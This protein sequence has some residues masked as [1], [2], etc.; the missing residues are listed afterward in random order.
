MSILR[1]LGGPCALP[2]AQQDVHGGT[3][4][5]QTLQM[6]EQCLLE[7]KLEG[8]RGSCAQRMAKNAHC[9]G[10]CALHCKQSHGMC[11]CMQ[12]LFNNRKC[13]TLANHHDAG[14]Y[15]TLNALFSREQCLVLCTQKCAH[16]LTSVLLTIAGTTMEASCVL[17]HRPGPQYCKRED[18]STS[19]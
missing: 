14:L 9:D 11:A 1:A 3:R 19:R 16:I 2:M 4:A 6:K 13:K 18:V 5:L 15:S 7:K 17:C 10:V 8:Q 12:V